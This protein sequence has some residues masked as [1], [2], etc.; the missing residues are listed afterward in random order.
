[1]SRSPT[2]SLPNVEA[3]FGSNDNS[4]DFLE[5]IELTKQFFSPENI[6]FLSTSP[7]GFFILQQ[8]AEFAKLNDRIC[9]K[10]GI[11]GLL[12][13][14]HKNVF[15]SYLS[16][17]III[18]T[19]T[20]QYKY[21]QTEIPIIS[22]FIDE[23]FLFVAYSDRTIAVFDISTNEKITTFFLLGDVLELPKYDSG[24]NVTFE[25]LEAA[26]LIIKKNGADNIDP[27]KTTGH[28]SNET[29]VCYVSLNNRCGLCN[30]E[31][32]LRCSQCQIQKYCSKECQKKHWKEHKKNCGKSVYRTI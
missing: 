17:K 16:N 32:K 15:S 7:M 29:Q 2:P 26:V 20:P 31:S 21:I 5:K 27:S 4:L 18:V 19:E 1:M 12:P 28:C 25:E 8:I 30:I 10:K 3:F 23:N 11:A 22:V 9:N 6:S 13:I 24:I 14:F